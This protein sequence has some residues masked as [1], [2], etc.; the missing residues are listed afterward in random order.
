MEAVM[1]SPWEDSPPDPAPQT[2]KE[3]VWDSDTLTEVKEF[4]QLVDDIADSRAALNAKLAAGKTALIDKGFNKHALAAAIK[5]AKTEEDKRENF[6]LT[7]LYC[8]KALGVPVQDDLFAA[9]VEEQVRP[10]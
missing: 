10:K 7:Y 4:A 2:E 9:A 6:D 5:Y 3:S 1:D 8:R